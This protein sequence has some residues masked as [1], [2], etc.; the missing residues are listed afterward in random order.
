MPSFNRLLV[1]SVLAL[2]LSVQSAPIPNA[3]GTDLGLVRHLS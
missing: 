3:E 1:L 2:T